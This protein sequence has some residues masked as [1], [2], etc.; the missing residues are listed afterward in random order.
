MTDDAALADKMTQAGILGVVSTEAPANAERQPKFTSEDRARAQLIQAYGGVLGADVIQTD[1]L[2]A[3]TKVGLDDEGNM[4]AAAVAAAL[5]TADLKADIFTASSCTPDNWP[6]LA[7]MYSGQ[8]VLVLGQTDAGLRI[9]DTAETDNEMTVPADEFEPYFTGLV[10]HAEATLGQLRKTHIKADRKLHWF[11]GQFLKYRTILGD[12]VMGSL[13]ANMLAVSVALFSLQVYDRVI[14]HES[15]ATLWVLATGA[16]IALGLEALLKISRARL[17]D[18]A[19]RAIEL[20][21][22]DSLMRRILGMR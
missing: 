2:E 1:A 12:I 20:K 8:F 11:W 10:V 4:T 22:Q 13:V 21:V 6:A 3:L 9:Y 5:A 14:P 19:G 17:M 18:G 16:F 15:S 7:Q